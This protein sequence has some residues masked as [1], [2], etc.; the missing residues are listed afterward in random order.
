MYLPGAASVHGFSLKSGQSTTST[1]TFKKFLAKPALS[2]KIIII[3]DKLIQA[4]YSI[5]TMVAEWCLSG[6]SIY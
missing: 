4:I 6:L 3:K 5:T 1:S 2:T